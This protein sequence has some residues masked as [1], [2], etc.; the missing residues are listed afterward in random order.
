M[1]SKSL[2]SESN[3]QS[4]GRFFRQKTDF[5]PETAATESENVKYGFANM[6]LEINKLIKL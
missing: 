2:F 5:T 6:I 1:Y 4:G 3:F